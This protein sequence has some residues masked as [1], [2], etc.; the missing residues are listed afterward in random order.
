MTA[1]P[2]SESPQDPPVARRLAFDGWVLTTIPRELTCNGK[3]VPLQDQPLQIL[4]ALVT[5]PQ[6]LVTRDQLVA[7]LW[8]RGVV[9][10]DGSL[11]TAVRKLRAALADD[12]DTPRYIETLPRQGYRFIG[13][14]APATL[15]EP[16]ET[17]R[18]RSMGAW[19]WAG[20]I[21]VLLGFASFLLLRERPDRATS[22]ISAD[23]IVTKP[24]IGVLPFENLSPD[25]SD[26]FFTEGLHEEILSTLV[27]RATNLDVI[28]RTTMLSYRATPKSVS[29]IASELGATHVLEGSVRREGRDVRLTLQLI[30]A[31]T[32]TPLW[33]QTYDRQLNSAMTLQT[34]VAAEVA[35]RL[36]VKLS[37]NGEQLPPSANPEA[38]DLYLKAKLEA[39]AL[40]GR[41]S[42]ES[43]ARV[44]AWLD[45]ALALDTSFAAA[46]LERSRLLLR[47]FQNSFDVSEMNLQAS[48]ADLDKARTL[49]G[50]VPAV[51]MTEI[52]Y[53]Q[54]VEGDMGKARRLMELPQVA[55][56]NDVTVLMG[57]A[58]LMAAMRRVDEAL[59]LYQE[60]ARL[61]PANGGL[62]ENW[63][64]VLWN[65]RR[66]AEALR[67]TRALAGKQ[68]Q[69]RHSFIFSFT[70]RADEL[71][72]KINPV[73]E[74]ID[75]DSRLMA[76]VNRYRLRGHFPEAIALLRGSDVETMRQDSHSPVTIPA[77][78]RK[79]VA[80]LHGWLALLT[81]DAASAAR[82]G[83]VLREFVAHEPVTKWN[84]W[85]LR[86]L[87]AEAA[88][89]SGNQ[90]QAIT[91]ARSALRLAPHNLNVAIDRY[92]P[93]QLA[94]IFAWAGAQ[95]ESVDLLERLSSEFPGVGPAEITR[96]PL[97]AVP[98]AK[99]ARYQALAKR[100]ELEI[101]A[102]RKLFVSGR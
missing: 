37:A 14:L 88:L 72:E 38:Y 83:R 41:A 46:Y 24:R 30:D 87:A 35:S 29:A 28:S 36:A 52:R 91:D 25:P 59:A 79:P 71:D 20:A 5:N 27:N 13:T 50:D 75:A 76:R 11:N 54:E 80:E 96:E 19:F 51:L 70:G 44:E 101:D 31:R 78:G 62:L 21:A 1:I 90:S 42:R 82:D 60:A 64:A 2:S 68:A 67:V 16:P 84:G 40:G 47:K 81:G 34:E 48:R 66:P 23:A 17:Q 4:E 8:P 102:N 92:L 58:E 7:R 26:A 85:F 53:A 32:D 63:I 57:R 98:L 6:Q 86:I 89:F 73:S 69:P 15:A 61:D 9:D 94:M 43:I 93:A 99:N 33:S 45:R 39:Q 49:A 55:A 10:F 77:I 56:S 22:P 100:L 65:A 3:R 12:A 74:S 95:E 97:Y 18:R